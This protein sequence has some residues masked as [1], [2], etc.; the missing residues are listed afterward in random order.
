MSLSITS[1][2]DTISSWAALEGMR[3]FSTSLAHL[4]F[5]LACVW[6]SEPF[7]LG[8]VTSFYPDW[9]L[10]VRAA[11]CFTASRCR[12]SFFAFSNVRS[13]SIC[14]RSVPTTRRSHIISSLVAPYSQLSVAWCRK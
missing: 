1:E 3:T 4:C 11:C 13:G 8:G 10:A 2:T 12:T 7:V 6:F 5:V 9:S 14:S